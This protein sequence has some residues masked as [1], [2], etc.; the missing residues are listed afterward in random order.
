MKK[1]DFIEAVHQ[2]LCPLHSSKKVLS[3]AVNLI[4]RPTLLFYD[5]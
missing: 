2:T 3:L 5:M 4:P 1:N